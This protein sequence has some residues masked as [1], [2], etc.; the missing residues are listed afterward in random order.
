[1][2]WKYIGSTGIPIMA[3]MVSSAM[4]RWQWWRATFT[5]SEQLWRNESS[6]DE[7][8]LGIISVIQSGLAR[9]RHTIVPA[10]TRVA[11]HP[12]PASVGRNSLC[13]HNLGEPSFHQRAG[14]SGRGMQQLMDLCVMRI[15]VYALVAVR[16]ECDQAIN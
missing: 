1:M 3:S 13:F 11:S 9:I 7:H 2:R 16:L 8:Q 4:L 10:A 12:K 6:A 15:K 5:A 14:R